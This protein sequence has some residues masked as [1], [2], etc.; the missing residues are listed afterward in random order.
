[1]TNLY[2]KTE[3]FVKKSFINA[4]RESGIKHLLRTADWVKKLKPDADESLL[5]AA[6]SHDIE[7]AFRE[8]SHENIFQ[9]TDKG[10]MAPEHLEKHSKKGSEIIG[11][12]LEEQGANPELI[13]KVKDL[14]LKHEIGGNKDEN[15]LKDA[16]SISFFENNIDFFLT[17]AVPKVGIK[18][19]E[20][21][22]NWML[23]RI[24]SRE[25]KEIVL[26][27]HEEA[28]ERLKG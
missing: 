24:T 27:W 6:V 12:F 23:D 13:Q 20:D 1:M 17:N 3:E 7:R 11:K 22:F 16:D 10:F 15:L 19:V 14:V 8:S 4:G 9:D 2:K 5:I 18:K 26:P 25:A 28:I 21:K